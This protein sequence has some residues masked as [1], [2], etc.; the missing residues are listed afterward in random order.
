MSESNKDES[1]GDL[2]GEGAAI[3]GRHAA[4]DQQRSREKKVSRR[5]LSRADMQQTLSL[6][7]Q[8]AKDIRA[9]A[10]RL[11]TVQE[12]ERRRIARDLHDETNQKLAL[13]G[14]QVAALKHDLPLS[15][16]EVSDRLEGLLGQVNALANDVRQL[17]HQLHPAVLEHLG[18]IE[19][20]QSYIGE[21][22]QN[23]DL[24]I[25]FRHRNVPQQLPFDIS[26]CLYRVAQECLGNSIKHARA[27]SIQVSFVGLARSLR[28]SVRDNG[29]GMHPKHFKRFSQQGLGFVS[30]RERVRQVKGRLRIQSKPR[31][32]TAIHVTIPRPEGAA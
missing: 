10:R 23:K 31:H 21:I 5:T 2:V 18:F 32:G 9:L 28:F 27:R 19:A 14:L 6:L 11:I 12:E 22:S 26:L 25:T 1:V 30:M 29:M 16:A 20:I 13:L 7:R 17:A 4:D 8:Q 15:A 3:V 24:V